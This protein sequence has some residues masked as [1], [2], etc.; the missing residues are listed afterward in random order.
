MLASKAVGTEVAFPESTSSDIVPQYSIQ[1]VL[2]PLYR[3]GVPQPPDIGD[4]PDFNH[5]LGTDNKIYCPITTLFMDIESSTRLSLL[6]PLEDVYHIKNAFIRAAMEII[7]SFD[8]HVH[9]IMGDAVMAYFGGLKMTPEAGVIDG[10]NCASVL[11]YFVDQSVVPKLNAMGFEDPFGIRVG[12]DFGKRED[13]LWSS[14]GYPGM[15]EVTATSFYVDVSSK[16]QQAAGRNQIMIGESI[17]SFIDFPEELLSVKTITKNG[18]KEPVTYL[19]PNHTNAEGKPINYSQHILN[20]ESYLKYSPLSQLST[21]INPSGNGIGLSAGVYNEKGGQFEGD[22]SSTSSSL[23]KNKWIKFKLRIPY[24]PM[25]PYTIKFIVENHGV[26]ARNIGGETLGN[27]STAIPI[28]TAKEHD[29]ISHW[30]YTAYR[31]LHYMIVEVHTH[32]GLKHKAHFGVY[33]E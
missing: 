16:L 14:Y 1:R 31:G 11:C 20:W 6:Y 27:H 26:E 21:E 13:V 10:L 8:G 12:V 25:L 4:H 29:D 18:N 22:Y 15:E 17:R 7:K 24:R 33:I 30:E 5:L 19:Q 9:R 23:P 3:K 32:L 2:R 28:R